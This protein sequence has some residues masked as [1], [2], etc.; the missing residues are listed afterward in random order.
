MAGNNNDDEMRDFYD[1]S[2]ME[3]VRNP[4][5]SMLKKQITI[6]IDNE[7]INYFK[8]LATETGIKYQQLINLYLSDCARKGLKPRINW[9]E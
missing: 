1:F 3:A 8:N 2:T 7:T 6:R 5:V 9:E 4:Y